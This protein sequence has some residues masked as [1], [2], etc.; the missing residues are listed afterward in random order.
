MQATT[1]PS[2]SLPRVSTERAPR[3]LFGAIALGVL[4]QALFFRAGLG[5]DW[6][7]WDVTMIGVT[8]R[9]LGR[10]RLAAPAVGASVLA[11]L[12]GAAFVVHRSD[13][14]AAVALP[15]NLAVLAVLPVLVA[16]AVE[17][18]D[19]GGLPARLLGTAARVPWAIFTTVLLPRD[20]VV[21]LDGEGRS[22]AR[23]TAAGLLLGLPIAGCFTLL[24][25]GDAG[26]AST[27]GRLEARLE[28]AVTF[29]FEAGVT[30]VMFA[31]GHGV[32][33][34]RAAHPYAPERAAPSAP[35]RALGTE[36]RAARLSSLTWGIVLAQVAAVF[37]LY[38]FVHR[39]TEFGGHEVVRARGALTYASNLHAGFY[40]LLLA[41]LLSVGLVV[42]GHQLLTA[43]G[44]AE[45]PGGKPLMA[46]EVAV[47]VLTGVAL[48]SCAHR[49]ALYEEAYGATL[50][51]LGVAFVVLAAAVVLACALVKS[52]IRGFRG[53]GASVAI[54]LAIVSLAAAWFDADAYVARTNLRR[55][56]VDVGYLSTLSA[57]ACA[58][59]P[60]ARPEV[61][62]EL[63][64]AWRR[65]QASGDLRG[66]RGLTRCPSGP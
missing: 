44:D 2:F 21:A 64:D 41:T 48:Y 30:A 9:V 27:V 42:S 58:A 17:L 13:F 11:A 39:D 14:T 66:L 50:L 46:L 63:L 45:V 12:L 53:F 56:Q 49:L 37:L 38:A 31:F 16:D 43:E 47:L 3:V 8:L 65:T 33:A 51:R 19:L 59:L 57:D 6:L 61:R 32:Y 52:A 28:T 54:G 34:N 22:V 15:L 29:A 35:Y 60:L 4:T 36:P 23:R 1:V 20:A 7:I 62:A 5:L 25:C 10:G 18:G 26:F 55:A 24:L 40:Q